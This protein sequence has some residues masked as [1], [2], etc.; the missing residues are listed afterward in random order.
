[1]EQLISK[2]VIMET[3]KYMDKNRQNLAMSDEIFQIDCRDAKELEKRCK[4][5]DLTRE[6]QML[7]NDYIACLSSANSRYSELSYLAGILDTVKVLAC[8]GLLKN[9][10][11]YTGSF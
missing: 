11:A 6:Q 2:L 10:A 5:L 4:A 9:A 8:W 7:I 1:M 3:V